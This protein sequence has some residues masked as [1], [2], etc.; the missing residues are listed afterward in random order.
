MR[1]I[2]HCKGKF[3][4][5]V[6]GDEKDSSG[7]DSGDDAWCMCLGGWLG[8]VVT[9]WDEFGAYVGMLILCCCDDVE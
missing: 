1:Y 6:C 4:V 9:G 7:D 8:R 5:T 2:K 3:K